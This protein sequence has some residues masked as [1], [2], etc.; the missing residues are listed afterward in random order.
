MT[1][2]MLASAFSS[3]GK[4]SLIKALII[5]FLLTYATLFGWRHSLGDADRTRALQDPLAEFALRLTRFWESFAHALVVARPPCPV[6]ELHEPFPRVLRFDEVHEEYPR[7]DSITIPDE[8]LDRF[9]NAHA[10]IKD[11]VL[12]LAP[13]LPY[14]SG[15]RGIVTTAGGEYMPVLLVS[16]RMLRRTGSTLPVEVF[17]AS[18][19]EYDSHVCEVVLPALKARCIVLSSVLQAVPKVLDIGKYQLKVFAILFSSFEDVLFL[20]ADDF[21][22]LN[23]D[24]ILVSEPFTSHGL[25]TW[26]DFWATTAAAAFYEISDQPTPRVSD[27]AS[28]ESGQLLVSKRTH[29]HALLL[30]AYYNYYGPD[31]FYRLLTQG[32]SGEGDKETF[33]A[34]AGSLNATSYSVREKVGVLGHWSDGSWHGA[35]MVQSHPGDD[36]AIFTNSSAAAAARIHADYVHQN[37]DRPQPRRLF[38]HANVPKLK[39]ERLLDQNSPAKEEHTGDG[40]RMWGPK[41]HVVNMFGRDIESEVWRDVI[42]TGCDMASDLCT[43][44]Q[45]HGKAVYG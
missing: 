33:L 20:D 16:L 19:D 29:G 34:A 25:V 13:G 15:T 31:C 7:V 2:L 39:P 36:Y 40:Q 23:P 27:L 30:A 4:Y 37:S 10:S 43:R 8:A 12:R 42:T 26:P 11:E 5:L 24:D 44:L 32:Q 18:A 9:K 38:V 22:V 45:D 41:D 35:G 1:G 14:M 21:P 28:T 3:H 6:P 17:V